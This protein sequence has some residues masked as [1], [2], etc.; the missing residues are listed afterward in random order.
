[1]VKSAHNII[2]YSYFISFWFS[3]KLVEKYNACMG[4]LLYV[5]IK[6]AR[7]YMY[8]IQLVLIY[9]K[10]R[11]RYIHESI[12]FFINY[13]EKYRKNWVGRSISLHPWLLRTTHHSLYIFLCNS[14][15]INYICSISLRAESFSYIDLPDSCIINSEVTENCLYLNYF[16]ILGASFLF[17]F[18]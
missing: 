3:T 15:F 10:S 11:P 1:M 4:I 17:P 5:L 7:L 18:V 16:F 2:Y 8:S 9:F 13:A 14:H 12:R 6:K